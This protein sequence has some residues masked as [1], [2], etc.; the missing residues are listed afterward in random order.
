[1][2]LPIA[3][4]GHYLGLSAWALT[5]LVVSALLIL[6]WVLM[7]ILNNTDDRR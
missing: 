6:R 2:I 3:S 1:M 5:G 7:E 4:Y